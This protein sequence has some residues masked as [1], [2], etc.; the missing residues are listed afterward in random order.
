MAVLTTRARSK[1]RS[2][3]FAVPERRAYPIPDKAHAKAALALI[4]HARGPGEKAR[5]RSK[6]KAMLASADGG[7]PM[8]YNMGGSY[9]VH[10]KGLRNY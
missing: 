9:Q 1:L 4:R 2:S 5:I 10:R 7:M 8:R 6:A 3:T